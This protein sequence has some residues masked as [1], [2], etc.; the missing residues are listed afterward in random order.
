[1][2]TA[3]FVVVLVLVF[4]P[5][6]DAHMYAVMG[7]SFLFRPSLLAHHARARLC[8]NALVLDGTTV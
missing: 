6:A 7:L 8:S 2:R 4:W 1:M 3:F 5:S